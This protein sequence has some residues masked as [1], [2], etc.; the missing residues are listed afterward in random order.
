ME[1]KNPLLFAH[2]L[3]I[4]PDERVL[5]R[6]LHY[7]NRYITKWAA[8][9]ERGLSKNDSPVS[10]IIKTIE[11]DL[12]ITL[13]AKHEIVL[14]PFD[15]ISI[16]DYNRKIFPFIIHIKQMITLKSNIDYQFFA[17]PFSMLSN[18]I[19][20]NTTYCYKLSEIDYTLN[21]VNV[22]KEIRLRGGLTYV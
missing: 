14:K 7:Q 5:L 8:T 18:H 22:I 6:K 17:M 4:L 20:T 21:T 13:T 1:N 2:A 11:T 19:L 16:S 15:S 3:I 12:G 10:V 9:I